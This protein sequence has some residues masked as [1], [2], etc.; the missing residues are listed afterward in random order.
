[1]KRI[2]ILLALAFGL[3]LLLS[4]SAGAE[5]ANVTFYNG[6]IT[7]ASGTTDANGTL[8]LPKGPAMGIR[9]FVGWLL[10]EG[11]TETL[12]P[13]GST[14]TAPAGVS[15]LCFE[16]FGV[17]MRSANGA[18]VTYASPARLRF[19]GGITLT[20]HNRLCALVGKENVTLG[21]L[22]A[23]Y[24]T[25]GT[26]AFFV[27]SPV[28]GLLN[29]TSESFYYT[30][31]DW[32][33]FTGQSEA[34]PDEYLLEKYCGRAYIAVTLA[35]QTVYIYADY[36]I[37]DHVRSA[38]GVTA[39]AFE[40]RSA[41]KA[42]RYDQRAD[43]GCYSPYG[44]DKLNLLRTRLDKVVYVSMEGEGL[45]ESKY[46]TDN[47]RFTPF[48]S[49]HYVSPYRVER[50]IWDEPTGA[51]TYVTYVITGV[52]GADFNTVTA[53]FIGDSYRRPNRTAEWREDGIYI[54]VR[55]VTVN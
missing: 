16:A 49:T 50:T 46:S 24:D 26:A 5:T 20:D 18:A 3:S 41:A 44:Q 10:R 37:E 22:I 36:R 43:E 40:D 23:P 31:G 2:L 34:I 17:E 4:L 30:M 11:E 1:M 32:G 42:D 55:T 8:T 39:V 27:D 19:Y 14:Y 6:E 52:N 38:Y 28:E 51:M 54:S 33:V 45:V 29:R 13:A 25:A 47:F 35:G 48:N 21:V 15:D 12:L 9:K 53:Y 7:I